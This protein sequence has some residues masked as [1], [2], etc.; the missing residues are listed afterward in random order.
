MGDEFLLSHCQRRISLAPSVFEATSLAS[1][2][3]CASPNM[4]VSWKK[5]KE[6][7]Y[8]F[9]CNCSPTILMFILVGRIKEQD[10]ILPWSK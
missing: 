4:A 3:N 9:Y 6:K 10:Y 7:Y 5:P 8:H 2:L 1:E